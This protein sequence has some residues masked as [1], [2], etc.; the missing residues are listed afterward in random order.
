MKNTVT[1]TRKI[2]ERYDTIGGEEEYSAVLHHV[3][4]K[5][6]KLTFRVT[7]SDGRTYETKHVVNGCD[8]YHESL[9][10]GNPIN[11]VD[12]F[13]RDIQAAE[14]PDSSSS[15]STAR[16]TMPPNKP[17]TSVASQSA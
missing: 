5:R 9:W 4:Y 10:L 2:K 15:T 11:G 13:T 6:H 7:M 1:K 12:Q 17:T 8:D 14:F 3:T 16:N